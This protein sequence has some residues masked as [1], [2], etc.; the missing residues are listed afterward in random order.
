MSATVMMLADCNP[1]LAADWNSFRAVVKVDM[2]GSPPAEPP[3]NFNKDLRQALFLSGTL[4]HFAEGECV[5]LFD[6]INAAH[7]EKH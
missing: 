5:L 4:L 3:R 2:M 1:A 6:G 7:M